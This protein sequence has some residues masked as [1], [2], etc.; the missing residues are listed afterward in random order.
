MYMYE[1]I[2]LYVNMYISI[3]NNHHKWGYSQ[4]SQLGYSQYS[5]YNHG[6][7]P[8]CCISSTAAAI[9]FTFNNMDFNIVSPSKLGEEKEEE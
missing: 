5:P 1:S 4:Y 2:Y 6:Y 9:G 3:C 7:I 8:I